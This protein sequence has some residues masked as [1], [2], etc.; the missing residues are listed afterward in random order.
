MFTYS[1]LLFILYSCSLLYHKLTLVD[2]WP[3]ISVCYIID[4]FAELDQVRLAQGASDGLLTPLKNKEQCMVI[5]TLRNDDS[6]HLK[7]TL[8]TNGT[9]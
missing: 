1:T 2:K 9:E 7:Q 8:V 3:E 5:D 6:V 4:D